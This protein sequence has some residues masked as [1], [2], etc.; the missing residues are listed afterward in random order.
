MITPSKEKLNCLNSRNSTNLH[1]NSI[2]KGEEANDSDRVLLGIS[3][4]GKGM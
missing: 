1:L 2:S 3:Q 4:Q